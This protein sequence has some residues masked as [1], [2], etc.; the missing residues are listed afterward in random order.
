[1]QPKHIRIIVLSNHDIKQVES[2]CLHSE[3]NIKVM[4]DAKGNLHLFFRMMTGIPIY[5]SLSQ[6]NLCLWLLLNTK[7][8]AYFIRECLHSVN[9][10]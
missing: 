6:V 3:M 7:N 8:N 5:K 1:M 10:A 2:K 9:M 4:Y